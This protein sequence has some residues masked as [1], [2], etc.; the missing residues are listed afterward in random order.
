[1]THDLDHHAAI[2]TIVD[3]AAWHVAR[4]GLL[5]R[6]KEHT[7]EGDAIAAARRRLPMTEVDASTPLT[8]VEGPVTLLDLF[9]GREELVIYKHMWWAG[10]PNE[11][12]CEG[13]TL[14]YWAV[15][16]PAYLHA[17]GVSFAVVAKGPQREL[18]PFVEFMGY[19]N[20][21]YSV[22]DVDDPIVGGD[23]ARDF[24]KW[25]VFLRR[26]ESVYLTYET[27]GRGTEATMPAL[28]L[29]DMTP[30]GRMESWQDYPAG[31]PLGKSPGWF[32]RAHDDGIGNDWTGGRPTI[33]WTRPGA[34]PV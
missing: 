31:W 12:Q 25:T 4:D 24:G 2:P 34:G 18:A 28:A 1:M 19:P 20:H 6:E 27:A 8:G 32:W 10:E 23:P 15:Q 14:T 7:R 29:L 26:D 30:R 22:A 5:A 3:F 16:T 13:C 17:R 21:W 9:E 11:R 33:Q